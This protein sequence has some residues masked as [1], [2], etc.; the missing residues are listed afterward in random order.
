MPEKLFPCSCKEQA[1]S[2]SGMLWPEREIIGISVN[3]CLT[4]VI[5]DVAIHFWNEDFSYRCSLVYLKSLF[6]ELNAEMSH[7]LCSVC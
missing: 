5:G 4:A 2:L 3:G 7:L 6:D 1:G